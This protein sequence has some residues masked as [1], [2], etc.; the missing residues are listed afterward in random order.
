MDAP[1]QLLIVGHE[2]DTNATLQQHFG[3]Q[4]YEVRV[5][6]CGKEAIALCQQAQPDLI[7]SD[8]RLPDMDG[9]EVYARLRK[10]FP[11]QH[12]PA[13]FMTEGQDRDAKITGLELGAADHLLKPLD[14]EEL[15]LRVR[16]TLYMTDSAASLPVVSAAEIVRQLVNREDWAAIYLRLHGLDLG[17]D[18]SSFPTRDEVLRAAA[19]T[20]QHVAEMGSEEDFVAHL[21]GADFVLVTSPGRADGLRAEL[22]ARLPLALQRLTGSGLGNAR[23]R[24][25]TGRRLTVGIGL[26]T[27]ADLPPPE[28][29]QANEKL[30]GRALL[31][32]PLPLHL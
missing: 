2:P 24:N 16:N 31:L 29:Q 14:L 4:G 22:E 3:Q 18:T 5:A 28:D 13:I 12:L 6:A 9:Y 15:S 1:Y 27:S 8:V 19:A 11:M 26:L 23:D 32:E 17:R 21:R 7:L 10:Q 20:L 30:T 25:P